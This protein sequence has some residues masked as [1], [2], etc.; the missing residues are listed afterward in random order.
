VWL[1]V[2]RSVPGTLHFPALCRAS[3]E[4]NDVLLGPHSF[5]PRL[6]RRLLLFVRLVH[7]YYGA[8]RLLRSVRVCLVA[9]HLR[10][11]AS[12][13]C[14]PRYSGGLPVLVH[15]VSQRARGLRL[16]RTD[17]SLAVIANH[18]VA[19]LHQERVDILILRFSK[20][21]TR[22]TDTPVYASSGISRCLL[23]D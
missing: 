9:W 18:R 22:P 8:V 17:C 3:V 12:F 23:Q 14:G 4:R 16:R 7:R 20:L 2:H 10:R 11:P 15:V 1:L 5:L 21:N 19:F 6:R 13:P